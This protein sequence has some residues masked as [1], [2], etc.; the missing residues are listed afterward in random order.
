MCVKRSQLSRG[1]LL[2]FIALSKWQNH[3]FMKLELAGSKAAGR[4]SVDQYAIILDD[5]L[6]AMSAMKVDRK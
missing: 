2:D 6:T 3:N 1:T 4:R 5:R